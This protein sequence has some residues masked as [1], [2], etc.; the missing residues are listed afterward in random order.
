MLPSHFSAALR[1]FGILRSLN[2]HFKK[3]SSIMKSTLTASALLCLITSHSLHAAPSEIISFESI[4]PRVRKYNPELAAA[5]FRID[6]ALGLAKQSGRL[7]NPSLDTGISIN[8][9]THEGSVEIGLT[10]KFPLTHRLGIEK[11]ISS[12]EIQAAEAEVEN[13]A[14]L[15][16]AEARQEFV[17]ILAIRDRK[18]LLKQQQDLATE[19][20]NFI[21]A[22][23]K[24]GES[25]TLDAA[26]AKIA[27]LKLTTQERQLITEETATLGKLRPLLDISP[28]TSITL[29]GYPS[30]LSVSNHATVQRPDLS[31]AKFQLRAAESG[32]TLEQAKRREDV[33]LSLFAA[34]E[35]NEDAPQGLANESIFGFKASIPL[36]FWNDNQGNIDAATARR[37][38]KHQEVKAL[39]NHIE[40]EAQT[41]LTEM[42][43]WAALVK[44]LDEKLL[45]LAEQ[46]TSLL[47]KAFR[48][49]QADLQTV[50]NSRDQTLALLATKIDA[51]RELRLANIRHQT[52]LGGG[53]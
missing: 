13:V 19:L 25:S 24:Q 3:F 36:P 9:R 2:L 26:Q 10:R 17:K 20:A 5:R 43:Q 31:S 35:R 4:S 18:N 41:A 28:E 11:E 23:S 53:F 27:S 7:S 48:E 30:N 52:A 6:E 33:E 42:R 46:Q 50:L 12:T 49:G 14:R 1:P 37:N 29:S 32:I 8:P 21:A 22:K 47:E 16:V 44:E 45:P 34:G 40:H 38:R 51:I 15:L 39:A